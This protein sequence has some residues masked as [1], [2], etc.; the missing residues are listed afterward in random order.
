M[1][2]GRGS[3]PRR[4]F[5]SAGEPEPPEPAV[6]YPAVPAT[7]DLA[8]TGAGARDAAR[9]GVS[10]PRTRRHQVVGRE[11]LSLA[12]TG[13]LPGNVLTSLIG[14]ARAKDADALVSAL[15]GHHEPVVTVV[16]ADASGQAGMQLAGW[17]PQRAL[18]TSLVPVPGRP[19]TGLAEL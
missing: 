9:A 12:W 6:A 15:A 18:P 8:D 7:E 13:M 5:P 1:A 16:Y 19:A 14:V 4:R 10:E 3:I 2:A 17:L 11:P